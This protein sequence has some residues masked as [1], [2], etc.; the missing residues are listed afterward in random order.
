MLAGFHTDR[1]IRPCLFH[2]YLPNRVT[3]LRGAVSFD[4]AHRLP[5]PTMRLTKVMFTSVGLVNALKQTA[6][7]FC[8]Q[9]VL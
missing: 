2:A 7:H 5:L 8:I 6:K 1:V 4:D 9:H 3:V